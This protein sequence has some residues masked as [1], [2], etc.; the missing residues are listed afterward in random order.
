MAE[1]HLEERLGNGETD[2][3]L[4]SL[5]SQE[6]SPQSPVMSKKSS[7]VDQKQKEPAKEASERLIQMKNE[8]RVKELE[9]QKLTAELQLTKQR[10]ESCCSQQKN[11]QSYP[12]KTKNL[13]WRRKIF[14]GEEKTD[15]ESWKAAFLSAVDRLDIP[16]GEKNA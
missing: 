11:I 1:Q 7:N 12:M 6:T 10:K 13:L 8:Q 15:Y 4:T 9:L 2:S 16:V 3:V 14:F 5:L